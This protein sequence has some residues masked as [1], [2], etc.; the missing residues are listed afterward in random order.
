[1][2]TIA[3]KISCETGP[4]SVSSPGRASTRGTV[5]LT[6][7]LIWNRAWR[8]L[9]TLV[10]Q[11]SFC[12]D[13]E[14]PIGRTAILHCSCERILVLGAGRLISVPGPGPLF[15]FLN[16]SCERANSANNTLFNKR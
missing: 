13:I 12:S 4:W 14:A 5:L 11:R 1:M 8:R 15:R 7:V 6:S 16:M 10:L 3:L 2:I 9:R